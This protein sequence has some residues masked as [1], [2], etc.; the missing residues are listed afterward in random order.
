MRWKELGIAIFAAGGDAAAREWDV[1]VLAYHTVPIWRCLAVAGKPQW[2]V[3]AQSE[4]QPFRC[5]RA[6]I[7]V[8][9]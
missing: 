5:F 7:F 9:R 6:D 3:Q 8:A 2:K 1:L 4:L